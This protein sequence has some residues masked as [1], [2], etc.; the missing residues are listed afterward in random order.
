[1]PRMNNVL[2]FQIALWLYLRKRAQLLVNKLEL[3][4]LNNANYDSMGKKRGTMNAERAK[5]REVF[6][7]L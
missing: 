2:H 4:I 7:F 1:M 3:I 6:V 5:V